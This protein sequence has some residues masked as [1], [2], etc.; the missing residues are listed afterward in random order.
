MKTL[1]D[2]DLVSRVTCGTRFNLDTLQGIDEFLS[3]FVE[4]K[5]DW[6]EQLSLLTFAGFPESKPTHIQ[7]LH[8]GNVLSRADVS[9]LYL[10]KAVLI[11]RACSSY[12]HL[13]PGWHPLRDRIWN[14]L[15]NNPS[16]K[17][18]MRGLI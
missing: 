13:L 9:K 3:L 12:K 4:G 14:A 2:T 17:H 7:L 8:I 15:E 6:A 18:L 5:T 16:R 11:L 1:S 10:P